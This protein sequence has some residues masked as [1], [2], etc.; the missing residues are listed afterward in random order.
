MEEPPVTGLTSPR[1]GVHD[2]G[3]LG[4][5]GLWATGVTPADPTGAGAEATGDAPSTVA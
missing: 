2:V 5:E 4:I 1:G 3:D